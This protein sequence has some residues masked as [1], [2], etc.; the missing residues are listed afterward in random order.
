MVSELPSGTFDFFPT[1]EIE[2][3]V[4]TYLQI[5]RQNRL[6]RFHKRLHKNMPSDMQVWHRLWYALYAA[7]NRLFEI[8]CPPQFGEN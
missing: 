1:G 5:R 8:S 2:A 4:A 3:E 7:C 6:T